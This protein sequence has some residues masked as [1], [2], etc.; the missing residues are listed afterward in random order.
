MIYDGGKLAELPPIEVGEAA[1]SFGIDAGILA[2]MLRYNSSELQKGGISQPVQRMH[3]VDEKGAITFTSGACVN[4]FQLAKP[5]RMLL[6][7]KVVRLFRLF[8]D[9]GEVSFS[10]GQCLQGSVKQTKVCFETP[11]VR[12][13]SV[14]PGED[15]MMESVPVKVIRGMAESGYG[16]SV[17]LSKTD[18][19]Q[20]CGRLM[21][22]GGFNGS[23]SG[24]EGLFEF[25]SVSVTVRDFTKS[26]SETIQYKASTL[27]SGTDAAIRLGLD[28][29]RDTL[30]SCDGDT[31]RVS[32]NRDGNMMLLTHGSI[33]N[34]IPL[35]GD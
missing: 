15:A 21:L 8:G 14:I 17:S 19:L 25:G 33:S 12:L 5:V 10:Y 11:S 9:S 23:L 28:G 6:P 31:V 22:M 27:P 7:D 30:A 2:G 32:F 24:N 4:S 20:A 18:L 34:I 35:M 26:N 13:A 16:Y 3:Y 1:E 29:L